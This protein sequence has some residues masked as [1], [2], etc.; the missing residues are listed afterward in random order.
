MHERRGEVGL[1]ADTFNR[2]FERENIE[3]IRN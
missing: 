1:L 3:A 2:Y